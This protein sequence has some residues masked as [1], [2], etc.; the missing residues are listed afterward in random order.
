MKNENRQLASIAAKLVSGD[1]F[2]TMIMTSSTDIGVR[3]NNGRDGTRLGP[4]AL[5]YHF[6]KMNNHLDKISGLKISRSSLKVSRTR[7]F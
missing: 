6:L 1:N 2:N 7:K 4:K 5:C 3:L